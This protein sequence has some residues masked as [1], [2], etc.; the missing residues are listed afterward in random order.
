MVNP[1]SS[2]GT[3]LSAQLATGAS[4]STKPVAGKSFADFLGQELNQVNSLS[5]NADGLA[6]TYAMGGNV[7][8]AQLMIAES[9]ATVAVDMLSQV[10]TRVQQAYS[11]MMN[12]QV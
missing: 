6:Q 5:Q 2:I 7:S 11:A 9:Q 3:G 12:M 10:G 1:V 8:T 4:S